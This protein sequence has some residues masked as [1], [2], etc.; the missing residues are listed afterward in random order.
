MALDTNCCI[1]DQNTTDNW[2]GTKFWEES[3]RIRAGF[4]EQHEEV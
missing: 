4:E 2:T 1:P 3:T